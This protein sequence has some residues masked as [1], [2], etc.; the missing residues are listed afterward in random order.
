M[1]LLAMWARRADCAGDRGRGGAW[2]LGAGERR[3]GS[4]ARSR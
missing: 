2:S 4:T 3:P 1:H